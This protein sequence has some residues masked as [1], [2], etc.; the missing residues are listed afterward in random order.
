MTYMD[1]E[2]EGFSLDDEEESVEEPEEEDTF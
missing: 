1:D 2:V